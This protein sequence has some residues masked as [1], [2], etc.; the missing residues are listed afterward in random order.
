SSGACGLEPGVISAAP[1]RPR[2]RRSD[3]AQI[4]IR[5]AAVGH[6][7]HVTGGRIVERTFTQKLGDGAALAVGHPR[8]SV[9]HLPSQQGLEYA[10]GRHGI[11]RRESRRAVV[12]RMTTR[13]FAL[14]KRLSW[15]LRLSQKR[16]CKEA[17]RDGK[18]EF[19]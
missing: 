9:T 15:R 7:G 14:K 2:R 16:A 6:L 1:S 3:I 4:R 12:G 17:E 11:E 13:A 8:G 18:A 5:C 19:S 10:L